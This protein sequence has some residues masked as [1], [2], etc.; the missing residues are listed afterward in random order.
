MLDYAPIIFFS[1][2]LREVFFI[3]DECDGI[4]LN[5][6]KLVREILQAL[7]INFVDH[8]FESKQMVTYRFQIRR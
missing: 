7:L 6:H 2:C 4:K 3:P 1:L 8:G 5:A